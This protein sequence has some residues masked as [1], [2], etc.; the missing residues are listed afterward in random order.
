M[1]SVQLPEPAYPVEE[2]L[3]RR[4]TEFVYWAY[5]VPCAGVK[6]YAYED[7]ADPIKYASPRETSLQK[8][9]AG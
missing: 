1:V 2:E 7:R 6:Y 5:Y 8:D 4:Q 3:V 9:R